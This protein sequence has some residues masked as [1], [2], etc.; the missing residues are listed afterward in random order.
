ML[1]IDLVAAATVMLITL[2]LV[3]GVQEAE[4]MQNICTSLCLVSIIMS[5]IVGE[6]LVAALLGNGSSR[7]C[8]AAAVLYRNLQQGCA[9][10]V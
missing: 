4:W 10:R 2:L 1:T 9:W 8:S 5:I 6:W 7:S 3:L